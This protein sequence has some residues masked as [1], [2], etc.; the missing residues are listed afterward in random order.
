MSAQEASAATK[1]GQLESAIEMC[2][3]TVWNSA[4]IVEDGDFKPESQRFFFDQMYLLASSFV[5]V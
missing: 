5:S 4:V 3:E 1:L 2:L